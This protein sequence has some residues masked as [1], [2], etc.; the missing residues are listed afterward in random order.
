MKRKPIQISK[1]NIAT[2]VKKK[3]KKQILKRTK[4]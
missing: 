2:T 1:Q 3:K 4:T